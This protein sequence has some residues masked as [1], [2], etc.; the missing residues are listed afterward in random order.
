ML[1]HATRLTFAAALIGLCVYCADDGA[2][3]ELLPPITVQPQPVEAPG[4][5]VPKGVEV[6]ARGPV[7]EAFAS[8][9][10]QPK[11]P[12]VLPKK[13]PLPIEEMP[14]D[15]RP[16]GDVVWIG[17]YYSWDDD[18]ADFLWV[19]GCWR[20][21]PDN[22]EWVPGYWREVGTNW[23]WVQGFWTQ[24][25]DQKAQAVT[26]YPEPPPPPNIAPAADAPNDDTIHV[27]GYWMW[28]G[29][30]YVWRA[31]YFTRIRPGYVYVSSHY[32]WTPHGYVFVAGY[33]DAA[34]SRRGVLY[35]PVIIDTAVVGPR[36]VYT[37]YYAV[38]GTVVL[39]TL[40]VR[41]AFGAYYFGDY[42]GPRYATIGFE[43]SYV[44]SRR[45]Y[46][47][48]IAYERW[49][50]RD[51]PRWHD[52][53]VTLVV[54][55]NAGRAP[56]P[57][58]TLVQQNTI[59]R[60]NVTNVTNITNVTNVTNV[61]APTKT[62]VAAQGQKVVAL[63]TNTRARVR[64]TAQTTQQTLAADRRKSETTA[65]GAAALTKPRTTALNVQP[66]A[67]VSAPP[68]PG[69][70]TKTP[71]PPTPM[72]IGKNPLGPGK[73]LAN[74]SSLKTPDVT[75]SPF[76]TEK[77]TPAQTFPSVTTPLPPKTSEVKKS[78]LPGE[79]TGP[80]VVRDSA[81]RDGAKGA[82]ITRP[83]MKK[84]EETKKKAGT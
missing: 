66:T 43:S 60:N 44:Y 83:P 81:V 67:S 52:T 6:Q 82:P 49:V 70:L 1:P 2:S 25:Q 58:R 45:H 34:I 72:G 80:P 11:A 29:D 84:A 17:G 71:T 5:E 15:E 26:Y 32:R 9:T 54:E 27:P 22:K 75:K 53:H 41:P 62:V 28:N 7:H 4:S 23:Q 14:P 18:R 19:S 78:P 30:R 74:P 33:W 51:N 38:R 31:G 21:K 50:Y 68:M 3:Q 56:L 40:F 35:A 73:T 46:E 37:P 79:K 8:P 77:K 57:P 16:E 55:R 20:V 13:P 64:D 36:Y 63:D 59:V 39:D 10:T 12:P 61:I 69:G 47:P 76:A 42:Y 65:P 24:M 48:I